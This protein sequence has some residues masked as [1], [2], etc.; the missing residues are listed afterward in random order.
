M[1]RNKYKYLYVVSDDGWLCKKIQKSKHFLESPPA[2]AVDKKIF[3]ANYKLR[4]IKGVKV[5]ETE[6]NVTYTASVETFI[7]FSIIIDRGF[8]PQYALPL[9]YWEKQGKGYEKNKLYK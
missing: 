6:E 4:K 8:E 2:I 3:D 5:F 9:K 1:N 7:Q